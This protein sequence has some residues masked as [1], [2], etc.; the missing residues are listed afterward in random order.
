L[1]KIIRT[2]AVKIKAE[3]SDFEKKMKAVQKSMKDTAKNMTDLG[4]DLTKYVTIPVTGAVAALGALVTKTA[5]YGSAI[6]DIADRTGLSTK[7]LQQ[8]RY[9]AGQVGMEFEIVEASFAKFTVTMKSA[10]TGSEKPAAL[11]K[12]LNIELERAGKLRPITELYMEAIRK[13][14]SISDETLQGL[15]ASELFGRSFESIMPLMRMSNQ[16][17]QTMMDR[18]VQLGLVL[19]DDTIQDLDN[20]D[21]K[22]KEVQQRFEAM[23]MRIATKLLPIIED[24]LIPA[25]EEKIIPASISL[26]EKI[27]DLIVKFSELD[28]GMQKFILG[29]TAL[30]VALGPTLTCLGG[31]LTALSKIPGLASAAGVS[32]AG[33]GAAAAVAIPAAATAA[34]VMPGAIKSFNKD[35]ENWTT[36]KNALDAKAAGQTRPLTDAEKILGQVAVPSSNEKWEQF[37]QDYLARKYPASYIRQYIQEQTEAAKKK[38]TEVTKTT[39]D[40]EE[41]LK[42]LFG[43]TEDGADKADNKLEQLRSTVKSF[44][45]AIKEQT[46]AFANFVGLFDI[47]ERKSVSGERLLNR[48]KAQVQAM[49]EW[50]NSLAT[51]EKRG[52]SSEMLADLR[53]MGPS[54]VDSINAL[55]KMTDAQLREYTSLYNQKYSIAGAES[56]KLFSSSRM[57]ETYIENQVNLNVTGSKQDAD[58]IV[59]V[60]VKRLRLAGVNI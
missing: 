42:K 22:L 20:L 34:I 54:A 12:A 57:A 6:S 2:V 8:L 24:K 25:L 27:G 41:A 9:V 4:K 44:I 48:L 18:A 17:L 37:K 60:I 32:L 29:A 3:T 13:I 1:S 51:L 16:E 33:L 19:R 56:S 53:A 47:F 45:D 46:R 52:I 55:A 14:G 10:L 35:L 49:G 23:G 30:S 38:Q 43:T 5:S 26:A 21:D 36:K 28:P 50:R 40:L 39:N 31:L 11:F 15:A 59:N 7:T 58:A